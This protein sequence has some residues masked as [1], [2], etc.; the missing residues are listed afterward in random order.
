MTTFFWSFGDFLVTF[1]RLSGHQVAC[2]HYCFLSHC[3]IFYYYILNY[4][5]LILADKYERRLIEAIHQIFVICLKH[6]HQKQ[7]ALW[8]VRALYVVHDLKWSTF[9]TGLDTI[10]S[11]VLQ[12]G[13]G[14]I[15]IKIP[16][17][18][19]ICYTITC[20][21]NMRNQFKFNF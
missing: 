2:S 14:T 6:E 1:L 15:L 4:N 16:L 19:V 9:V 7:D 11:S 17:Y 21:Q 12:K 18:P 3:A 20:N 5:H 10:R 13:V 8:T